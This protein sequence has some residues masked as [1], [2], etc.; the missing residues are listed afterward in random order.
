MFADKIARRPELLG[1]GGAVKGNSGLKESPLA[2]LPPSN[3]PAVPPVAPASPPPAAVLPVASR[4]ALAS[5]GATGLN[6]LSLIDF[7]PSGPML[8]W[9][10]AKST[11]VAGTS[12]Q[13]GMW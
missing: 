13:A 6:G 1:V 4:I 3:V 8:S 11:S 10:S 9:V 7:A 12:A 2:P 5:A